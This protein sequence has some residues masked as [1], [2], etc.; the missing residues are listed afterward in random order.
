MTDTF[1]CRLAGFVCEQAQALATEPLL[2]QAQRA[3]LDTLAV[4]I[5]G[6][7]SEGIRRLESALDTG[8][9][10]AACPSPWSG[11]RYAAVDAAL[12]YGMASHMDDYDDVSM[13]AVCHPSAPVL[14]ALLA[15]ELSLPAE[16]A[17]CGRDFVTAFAT[18]TEVMIRLGQAMGFRH[19]ELGFHATSTLGVVG[20]AAAVAKLLQLDV[21]TTGHALAIAASSAGGV[22]KNFGSMV[23]PLHVGLAAAGGL[24]A[25]RL[26][27][28]GITG[29]LEAFEAG[30]YLRAYSG[31]ETDGF[32]PTGLQFGRPFVLEQ[33]GFEQKRYPCC[34]MLHKLIEATL[35]LRRESGCSLQDL[36]HARVQLPKGGSKPLIHPHPQSGMKGKFSAPYVLVASLADGSID[37]TRFTDEAVLRPALQARFRDVEVVEDEADV[38]PGTDLGRMPVTVTLTLRDGRVLQRQV[39][40]SPGSPGDPLTLEQLRRKWTDCLRHGRPDVSTAAAGDWFDQGLEISAMASV[41]PWLDRVLVCPSTSPTPL[42]R[43]A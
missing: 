15:A 37:L 40:A 29:A 7:S 9:G 42:L 31:G 43:P 38:P 26:A 18:G 6:G 14:S 4:M 3:M 1:T 28:A 13:L 39:L 20:S 5:A 22:R 12:L 35:A 10:S 11:R 8:V 27:Q 16:S 32:P 21:A 36:Q 30:G 17:H 2:H 25:A 23:K 24:R 34:Y 19:Y 33:P 41:R